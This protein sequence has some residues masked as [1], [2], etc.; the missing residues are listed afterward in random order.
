MGALALFGVPPEEYWPY[1]IAKFDAEPPAFC[2]AFGQSY[3]EITF[4]RLDPPQT[5]K[6]ALLY[7]IKANLVANLPP[8]FGFT[9][10]SSYS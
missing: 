9:V 7:C 6:D 5:A 1:N 3:Q 4:Y 2:C 8:T 10:Y